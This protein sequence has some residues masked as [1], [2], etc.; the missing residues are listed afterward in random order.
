[1]LGRLTSRL[2]RR[3]RLECAWNPTSFTNLCQRALS[4]RA[5]CGAASEALT[6]GDASALLRRKRIVQ[7]DREVPAVP[8]HGVA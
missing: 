6:E 3:T 5:A 2:R 4:L 8:A 7:G 1:M